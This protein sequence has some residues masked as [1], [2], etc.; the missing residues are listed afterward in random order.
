MHFFG[1]KNIPQETT[2]ILEKTLQD[3]IENSEATLFYVGHQGDFDRM[4][5]SALKKL[6]VVYPHISYAVALAY[7]PNKRDDTYCCE[8][9]YP[10]G[11]E[12]TPPKFAISKRNR[13]MVEQAD[14]VVT[15]VTHSFGG[16]AQFKELAE[17][18]G[19]RVINLPD[20]KQ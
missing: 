9:V 11:L 2:P 5:L 12:Y 18:R 19:K 15:Y 13:W 8:T 7:F 4:V 16:A 14:I 20:I 1:H 17:K 6:N 3:L 10:D